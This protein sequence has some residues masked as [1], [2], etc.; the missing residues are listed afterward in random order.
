MIEENG[1]VVAVDPHGVS[2]KTTRKTACQG[3][4]ARKGC[5][6]YLGE[7]LSRSGRRQHVIRLE[8][9]HALS[10]GD[11]VVIGIGAG[12]LLRASLL[13]YLLP[14]LFLMA[15]LWLAS[16]LAL[17]DSLSLLAAAGGLLSGLILVRHLSGRVQGAC[18]IRVL[19]VMPA[20]QAGDGAAVRWC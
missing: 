20:Q 18:D 15:S 12:T 3:C 5:G 10:P 16:F 4:N 7:S 14:L 9:C 8:P 2:L 13:M 11:R 19:E 17:S 6:Q 1:V